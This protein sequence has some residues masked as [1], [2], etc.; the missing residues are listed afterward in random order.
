MDLAEKQFDMRQRQ[1]AER[2]GRRYKQTTGP[3]KGSRKKSFVSLES[4]G[5]ISTVQPTDPSKTCP[6]GHS[7]ENKDAWGHCR[8]C[9][10]ERYVRSPAIR[11]RERERVRKRRARNVAGYMISVLRRNARKRGHEFALKPADILPLPTH[12]PILGIKLDYSGD[13]EGDRDNFA[14]V[15]R[16]DSAIGYL[17]G[18]VT[19]ISYRANWL[20]QDATLDEL[21]RIVTW[22]ENRKK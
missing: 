9:A 11:K 22:M 14:S 10:K 17:P 13:G 12:C 20:K 4:D 6:R 15:D 1:E 5:S 2:V 3:K 19:V 7:S 21:K 18:N 16:F 8:L